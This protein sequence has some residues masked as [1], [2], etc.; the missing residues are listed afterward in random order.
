MFGS[1]SHLRKHKRAKPLHQSEPSSSYQQRTAWLAGSTCPEPDPAATYAKLGCSNL[2]EDDKKRAVL[3]SDASSRFYDGYLYW[4]RMCRF[5]PT[6]SPT[7]SLF[8]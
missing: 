5:A 2:E 6:S 8:A 4:D 1:Q 7:F 3:G